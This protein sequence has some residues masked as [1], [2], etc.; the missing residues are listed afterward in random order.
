MSS[1]AS[2]MEPMHQLLR[3][4]LSAE[5]LAA[6]FGA[7]ASRARIYQESARGHIDDV[8][9]KN[10][11]TLRAVLGPDVWR[12]V[13]DGFFAA[14]PPSDFELNACVAALPEY[15][16]ELL[17]RGE[18]GIEASHCEIAHLERLE[19]AVYVSC[20][21]LPAGTG[22]AAINPTLEVLQTRYP[23]AT[24]VEAWRRWEVG[25]SAKPDLP[26]TEAPQT[27]LVFRD[28]RTEVYAFDVADAGLLLALKVVVE[29][30][31]VQDAARAAGIAEVDVARAV[32]RASSLGIVVQPSQGG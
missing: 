1:L 29:A 12:R 14:R 4:Q 23:V 11:A 28:S 6:R 2:I 3:G 27:V 18:P 19:F 32:E 15:L 5:D 8:L 25:E 13:A 24:F 26:R 31:A 7:A 9:A 10:Y 16:E 20:E 21:E 17:E 30:M 22:A